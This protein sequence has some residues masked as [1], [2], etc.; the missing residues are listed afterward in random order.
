LVPGGRVDSKATE[1]GIWQA[2]RDVLVG[3]AIHS[4]QCIT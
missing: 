4:F 3:L 2:E 1:E